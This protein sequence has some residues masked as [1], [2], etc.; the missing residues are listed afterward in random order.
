[1]STNFSPSSSTTAHRSA[2]KTRVL[3]LLL[4]VFFL[5]FFGVV[6]AIIVKSK[7][8]P[9]QTEVRESV[10]AVRTVTAQITAARPS[11][12]LVGEVEAR[13]Y[14]TLTAP[15]EAEVLAIAAREG[16]QVAKNARL[17]RLDLREQQLAAKSQ[18]AAVENVR[19]QLSA[20]Q[21]NRAADGRRPERNPTSA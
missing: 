12:L 19:L 18:R 4:A 8:E 6:A 5:A 7:P 2:L 16:E 20:L 17:L 21:R 3:S 14:T 11:V 13:D 9:Q 15:V 1:M 10:F